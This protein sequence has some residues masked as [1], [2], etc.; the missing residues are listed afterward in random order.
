L[1]RGAP[2]ELPVSILR[3]GSIERTTTISNPWNRGQRTSRSLFPPRCFPARSIAHQKAGLRL[4][5]TTSSVSMRST[6]AVTSRPCD[7][8][9]MSRL[10]R[11]DK[12]HV[13]ERPGNPRNSSSLGRGTCV[14]D[15]LTAHTLPSQ[16]GKRA[17]VVPRHNAQSQHTGT[18]GNSAEACGSS[19]PAQTILHA[20][21][22]ANIQPRG[23]IMDSMSV[24][25]RI[26]IQLR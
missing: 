4:L 1:G 26:F 18:A 16:S 25:K 21:V 24:Q 23:R 14:I 2:A 20:P 9:E 5:T 7:A 19:A 15:T 17:F 3:P 10:R 8:Q 13:D 12:R 6:R 11:R 22:L